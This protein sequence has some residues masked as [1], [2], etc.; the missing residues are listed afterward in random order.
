M[1]GVTVL[2]PFGDVFEEQ[3]LREARRILYVQGYSRLLF[4]AQRWTFV[5]VLRP[6]DMPAMDEAGYVLSVF[7]HSSSATGLVDGRDAR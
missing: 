4:L 6:R 5:F 3:M 7:H 1:L 2:V